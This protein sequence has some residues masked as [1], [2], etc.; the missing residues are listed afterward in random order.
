MRTLI[1]FSIA[2]ITWAISASPIAAAN[3]ALAGHWH[4]EIEGQ[5]VRIQFNANGTGVADGV[6]LRYQTM[7]RLLLVE[8]NGDVIT[9]GWELKNNQLHVGG[10]D[11]PGVLMLKRGQAPA[12]ANNGNAN[13]SANNNSA[14]GVPREL[15]GKWCEVKN[16][17]ANAGGGSASSSCFELRAD[18][19]YVYASERSMSAY[20]PGMY[21]G[22][23]SSDSDAGRW[24]ATTGSITARSQKGSNTT[25]RLEKRN[26][27]RNGDPML[28]LNGDCYVT[29]YQKQ[30]W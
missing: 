10:G 21:G 1:L 29:Y 28:C 5:M 3:P 23:T 27:P 4:G 22:T 9:Y 7:G 16:F 30:P 13:A 26:H 19:S 2:L 17:N 8:R 12:S 24:S 18:G 25:Y 20:A 6:P 15:V 11:L 14:G